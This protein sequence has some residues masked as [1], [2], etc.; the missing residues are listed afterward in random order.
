M[1]GI[2]GGDDKERVRQRASLTLHRNL[3]LTHGFEQRTLGAR[4]GPVD[5]VRQ[6]QLRENGTRVEAE[7]VGRLVEYGDAENI[8]R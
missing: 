7:R 1:P 6:H 3:A 4:G 5:F 8:R 2:L